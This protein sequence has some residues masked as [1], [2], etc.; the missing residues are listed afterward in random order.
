MS[1]DSSTLGPSSSMD[2]TM[3]KTLPMSTKDIDRGH[4]FRQVT[5]GSLSVRAASALLGIS[6]R[7]CYRLLSRF[8]ADG[9]AGLIHGLRGRPSNNAYPPEA[10]DPLIALYRARY[11]DYGPTLFAE[12]LVET[13]GF[14]LGIETLRRWLIAANVW[15]PGT[16]RTRHRTKRPRRAAIGALVQIDGSHHAWFED[17]GPSC[18]LFVFIDD[19]SNRTYFRFAATENV[20]D[21]LLTLRRYLERFGIFEQAYTDR[22][23]VY[24]DARAD[25]PFAHALHVLHSEIIF[26]RSPQAKG[27]VERANRTHQ[28]R[29]VKALRDR[30][31]S[32]IEEANR[33]LEDE[34]IDK[35]NARFARTDGLP[36]VHRPVGD[37]DLDNILCIEEQR[38][39]G[40]DMT[41][42][43][44]AVR[45]QILPRGHERP[46][47]RQKVTIRIW[48]DGSLHAFWREQELAITV[49]TERQTA[50]APR[51]PSPAEDHPWR[52][53]RPIGK[54]K[55]RTIEE[56]CKAR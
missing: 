52:H 39:V 4:V 20:H 48:L 7:Q 42:P 49:C 46:L 36:D 6:E 53:A 13:L 17:R 33:F 19:A 21:A 2:P 45:Y 50:T 35:H 30:N 38:T 25:T 37:L 22:G 26:A 44:R 24:Y 11:N 43:Y 27:R 9:D 29:L 5:A 51:I 15:F 1:V 16:Y 40:H 18:C 31:I 56:L 12:T 32:T 41:F 47:P 54:A 34:Y 28:D 14:V 3:S 10:R 55:R 23:A 8:R